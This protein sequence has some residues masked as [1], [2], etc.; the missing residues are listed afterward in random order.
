MSISTQDL[1]AIQ[2]GLE[3]VAASNFGIHFCCKTGELAIA[4]ANEMITNST[5][6]FHGDKIKVEG[7]QITVSPMTANSWMKVEEISKLF[8]EE[9]STQ[10][11]I[12]VISFL[13][14]VDY[15]H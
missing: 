14:T 11:A 3:A 6:P 9:F 8:C 5:N 4:I 10:T 12:P 13:D 15:M 7:R 1:N 2:Q